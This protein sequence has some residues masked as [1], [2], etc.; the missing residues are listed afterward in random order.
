MMKIV[1]F[2]WRKRLKI[3]MFFMLFFIVL[4]YFL[5]VF[6][7]VLDC[8]NVNVNRKRVSFCESDVG[9][10]YSCMEKINFVFIKCM[11][12]VIEIMGIIIRRFG[13]VW[14]L[15]FVVLVKNNIYLG[16]F[17]V[18]EEMDYRFFK[19]FFNILMEYV[20]YNSI[21][22]EKIMLNNVVYII[23]IRE[24]WRRLIFFFW[25][26]SFG[27]IVEFLVNFSEYI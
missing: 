22:M 3:I 19:K 15:N 7:L 25:Y 11:K 16:W 5:N 24:L 4:V 1:M 21:K 13:F 6:F 12:C 27:Y 9:K 20:V 26:F 14:N 2:L 17:F 18:I 23:I 10:G 8:I